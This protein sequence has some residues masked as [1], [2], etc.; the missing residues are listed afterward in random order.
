MKMLQN[1]SFPAIRSGRDSRERARHRFLKIETPEWELPGSG[2]TH[3]RILTRLEAQLRGDWKDREDRVPGDTPEA[4]LLRHEKDKTYAAFG[5][6]QRFAE[7][8]V[9]IVE[10]VP[11]FAFNMVLLHEEGL[12]G[13]TQLMTVTVAV[14]NMIFKAWKMRRNLAKWA[15]LKARQSPAALQEEVTRALEAKSFG[16]ARS[17]MENTELPLT[18]GDAPLE[19]LVLRVDEF[20]QL[21]AAVAVAAK[22]VLGAKLEVDG[23]LEPFEI[24]KLTDVEDARRAAEEGDLRSC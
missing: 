15:E 10:D 22:V 16:H 14:S 13:G 1:A 7:M 19:D 2:A 24:L 23:K 6:S 12:K 4:Y 5:E 21:V 9:T 11:S 8:L 20:P 17:I 3:A 18:L